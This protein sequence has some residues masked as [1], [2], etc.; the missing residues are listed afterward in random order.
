MADTLRSKV[1]RLA[2]THPEIRPHLLPLLKEAA[3][4]MVQINDVKGNVYEVDPGAARAALRG[5]VNPDRILM[6]IPL[7]AKDVPTPMQ[8]KEV[9]I[10]EAAGVL[11]KPRRVMDPLDR[12]DQGKLLRRYQ[13]LV[14]QA[15]TEA[16]ADIPPGI[17]KDLGTAL[18]LAE[19]AF[20]AH[21]SEF[22]ALTTRLGIPRQ[23]TVRSIA[24]L[25]F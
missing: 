7:F 12:L 4:G 25:V 8:P 1:I 19:G 11:K 21:E 14:E 18:D 5:S 6:L 9:N 10:L 23:K 24:E 2:Y 13:R 16:R 20:I 17:E 15:A 22:V 3:A